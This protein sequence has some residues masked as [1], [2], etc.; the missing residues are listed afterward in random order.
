MENKKKMTKPF[1][2]SVVARL[3]SSNIG[4]LGGGVWCRFP[5]ENEEQGEGPGDGGGWG[6]IR[7]RNRQVN[8]HALVKTTPLANYPCDPP[9]PSQSPKSRNREIPFS[10]LIHPR[11][12]SM[13][14]PSS[15][16]WDRGPLKQS[17]MSIDSGPGENLPVSCNACMCTVFVTHD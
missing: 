10:D 9:R 12:V 5:L 14:L 2:T 13:Y 4:G 8:A 3:F 17:G 11:L 7:Q 6:W 1:C 15:V 16:H